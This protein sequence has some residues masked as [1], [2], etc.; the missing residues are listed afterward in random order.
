MSTWKGKRVSLTLLGESHSSEIT[1]KVSGLPKMIVNSEALLSFMARRRGGQGVGT[2][3][4]KEADIPIFKGGI[5]GDVQND[6]YIEV[7]GERAEIIIENS[8]VRSSDY[9]PLYGKPRPSHADYVSFIKNGTL[10]FRGGGRFSAR[11][12]APLVA[13][14]G[15]LKQHLYEKGIRSYS[16]LSCVGG[17]CGTSYKNVAI[18]EDELT[19]TLKNNDFP[20]LSNTDGM[21]RAIEEARREGDSVG[22]KA[23]CIA[24]GVKPGLGNDYF[25]ALEC[26]LSSLLFAIPAVKALEFGSGVDFATMRG[27]RA[28][29]PLYYDENDN[30]CFKTN[31]TGGINGGITNGDPLLLSL[32]FRPTPSISKPQQTVDLV[33]KTNTEISIHGRH[34]ACVAVRALPI[35]ESLVSLAIFD[36]M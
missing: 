20:A 32:T 4:R 14:G 22:A 3:E 11:L 24:F 8:N 36:E 27:S 13:L 15:I 25:D 5:K 34:D 1:L 18:T 10:D 7:L 26:C 31:H 21:K 16:Y 35:I 9:G 2:T 29:D 30:V 17:E 12:T 6:A 33:D 28:N 19:K 23:E